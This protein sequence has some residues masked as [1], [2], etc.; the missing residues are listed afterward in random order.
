MTPE[1]IADTVR[2]F[3]QAA[4]EPGRWASTRSSSMARTAI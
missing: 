4:A 1:D 3:A 2:A